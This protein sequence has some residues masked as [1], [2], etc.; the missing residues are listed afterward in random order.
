MQTYRFD[1]FT[2]GFVDILAAEQTDQRS[3]WFQGP[4]D[5]VRAT[6]NHTMYYRS[7]EILIL[8][9]DQLYRMDFGDLIRSHR[10][11]GADIT[12]CVYPVARAEAK[13][14]G[15]VAVDGS[16]VVQRFVEKPQEERIIDS[17]PIPSGL[18]RQGIDIPPDGALGSMGIYVFKPEVLKKS[19]SENSADDFG[20]GIFEWAISRLRVVAYPFSGYWRDIGTV[21]AFFEAN[22]SL[23]KLE[24]PFDLY[25]PR[26]PI[27]TR[28]R[29]LPPSRV[30]GSEI[31]DSLLCE[32]SR[33]IRARVVDSVVGVRSIIREGTTLNQ[34]VLL[35]EDFYE[36][37]QLLS[38]SREGGD[39]PPMGI[40]RNCLIE[41]AIIDKNVR[42]GD[43]V[44]IKEKP[45][46]G[47]R[48]TEQY[49]FRDGITVIPKGAVIPPGTEI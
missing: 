18:F 26:W 23:G 36:G 15:L 24:A 38:E 1:E 34:V 40:G 2:D 13:R 43:G 12:I 5:A 11:C 25:G 35:G 46:A 16:R 28:S 29:P 3:D 6:L 22:I 41:R 10:E 30:I 37:E 4:A 44:V 42:I 31:R 27:Y 48:Q 32:G 20:T 45:R 21:E 17:L 39:E 49:W 47:A 7:S 8:S 19:L 9:G 14:M 33:I